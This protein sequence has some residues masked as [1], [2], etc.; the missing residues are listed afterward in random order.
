MYDLIIIG[1][2]PSG[3]SAAL[4]AKRSNLNTLILEKNSPGG[5][6]NTTNKIDNYLG[7]PSVTGPELAYQMFKHVSEKN[8]PFK[9][10]EVI[11]VV[12]EDNIFKVT[13]NKGEYTSK[14]IIVSSGRI[15][16]KTTFEEKVS[17]LKLSRCAICDAPLYKGKNVVVLGGGLSAVEESIY[18]AN[19][20]SSVK[21]ISR[22]EI[23]VELKS[24]LASYSNI[25]IIENANIEDITFDE[26]V[27][28]LV[29]NGKE[30]KADGVFSYIGFTTST[31]YLENLGVNMENG[32]II[33]SDGSTNIPGLYACGDIIKKKLYQIV[34]AVS[35]G[36]QCAL[37]ASNYVRGLNK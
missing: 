33:T 31:G 18:L 25:D 21:I 2:G 26:S 8:I 36:A 11:N 19:I 1:M 35:E 6:V 12:K 22:S 16:K 3:M 14:S 28:K 23:K 20:A 4:Y 24:E 17:T 29:V 10:E 34:T 13:T 27:Y 15:P 30:I 7:I 32:Y 9:I 37:L 5:L